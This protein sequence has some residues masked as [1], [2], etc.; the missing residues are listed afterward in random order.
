MFKVKIKDSIFIIIIGIYVPFK[1]LLATSLWHDE[2]ST[3]IRLAFTWVKVHV[4]HHGESWM[5]TH[6]ARIP[7][8]PD[9]RSR[10]FPSVLLVGSPV[11]VGLCWRWWSSWWWC[12]NRRRARRGRSS[13]TATRWR[14]CAWFL[15]ENVMIVLKEKGLAI[16]VVTWFATRWRSMHWTSSAGR[17]FLYFYSVCVTSSHA[18]PST[19]WFW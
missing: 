4:G 12:P 8:V 18:V 7:F 17:Q 16:P 1:Y 3:L 14:R 13:C 11:R 15:S 6:P 9:V 5:V 19:F 2:A 10:E